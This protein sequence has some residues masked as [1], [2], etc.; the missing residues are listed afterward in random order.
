MREQ[1]HML[2]TDETVEF[3]IKLFQL[4]VV[5]EDVD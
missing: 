5:C 3:H 1:T 2:R 4:E